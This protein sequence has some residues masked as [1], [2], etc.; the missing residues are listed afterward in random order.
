MK[1]VVGWTWACAAIVSMPAL[2]SAQA[3]APW[4][5]VRVEEEHK[6]SKVS[7]NVPLSVAEAA[8]AAAPSSVVSQGKIQLG[9]H[10]RGMSV[11]SLRKAWAE[12][13][14]S[15][16]A[17][18][19]SVEETDQTV[20]ISREADRVH[21]RVTSTG[22]GEKVTVEVP[23]S[24]VDALLAGDGEDLDLK[25]ALAEIK[26]VRGDVVQVNDGDSKVRIW[27]DEGI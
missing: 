11:A 10:G 15:G 18:F 26:K 22:K 24:A 25:G 6:N 3:K 27:I 2:A 7:V 1:R 14:K 12:L 5:H 23:V 21:V 20:K 16:D 19:V 8:L 9:C 13:R 17:E 4:I